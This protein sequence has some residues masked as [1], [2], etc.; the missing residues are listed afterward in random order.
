MG[1]LSYQGSVS[2]DPVVWVGNVRD[3][4]DAVGPGR[5]GR[6]PEHCNNYCQAEVL[7][8]GEFC[9]HFER[10]AKIMNLRWLGEANFQNK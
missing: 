6:Q 10:F 3:V 4:D 9:R 7:K 1:H 8:N 5:A 2:E